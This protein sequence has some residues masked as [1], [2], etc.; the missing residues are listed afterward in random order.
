MGADVAEEIVPARNECSAH[1]TTSTHVAR[2]ADA[3]LRET[4]RVFRRHCSCS[5]AGVGL[6]GTSGAWRL[7]PETGP[8]IAEV[9]H[10]V[11]KRNRGRHWGVERVRRGVL[12]LLTEALGTEHGTGERAAPRG[13]VAPVVE[14]DSL[15][16]RA[17]G[18]RVGR[19]AAET[20]RELEQLLGCAAS[21]QMAAGRGYSGGTA[22]VTVPAEAR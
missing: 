9:E 14:L 2:E 21:E 22:S 5:L 10:P 17:E 6:P 11:G 1:L 12:P 15:Q 13:L 20:A 4:R 16:R 18:Q 19:A 8:Q 7:M 3:P